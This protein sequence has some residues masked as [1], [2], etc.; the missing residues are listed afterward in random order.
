MDQFVQDRFIRRAASEAGLDYDKRLHD[1]SPSPFDHNAIDTGAPV[2]DPKLAGQVW[3]KGSVTVDLYSTPENALA[4]AAKAQAGDKQ[5]RVIYV[6]DRESGIKLFADKAWYVRMGGKL[7]AFL[8]KTQATAWAQ[9]EG[10][11]VIPFA[12]AQSSAGNKVASDR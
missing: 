3:I 11:D 2:V 5:V 6:H 8:L 9:K 10:G 1:Y 7:A 4:A 12:E